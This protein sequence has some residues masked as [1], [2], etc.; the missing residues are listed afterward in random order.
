MKSVVKRLVVG[1]L[2][3][4]PLKR[5]HSGLTG[6]RNSRYDWQTIAIMRR[7]LRAD[8][9][10]IDVGAFE[11]G[12][13]RHLLRFA[14]RGRHL[15]F[16]PIRERAETIAMRFPA[17]T[18]HPVALGD[19][20]GE[21]IFHHVLAHPALSGLRRRSDLA[22]DE[23]V[24]EV[25]VGVE[26]LDRLVPADHPVSFVKIDVEGGELGV[27][28]G[29]VETLRRTKPVVV[30]EC[31][32]GSADAYGVEPEEVYDA[33]TGA[34]GLKISLLEA[35]LAGSGALSRE[36]FADQYRGRKNFYFVAHP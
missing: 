33:V 29:G 14:P 9:N 6:N 28:R 27:F 20:P 21:T 11:G 24:S 2:W 12:M 36:E 16:E 10:G 3:E 22:A 31:G 19:T 13:L 23:A 1:T 7:V 17:A 35:W 26:T 32:L 18:V 5:V 4:A 8:S 30:F 25:R 15:A 34:V